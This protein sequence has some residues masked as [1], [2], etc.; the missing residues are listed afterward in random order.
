MRPTKDQ[1]EERE[2]LA[3]EGQKRCSVRSGCGEIKSVD[4]FGSHKGTWDNKN[5]LCRICNRNNSSKYYKE[6]R[7]ASK[8]YARQRYLDNPEAK[9]EYHVKRSQ[10]DPMHYRLQDGKKRAK[11]AGAEWEHISSTD[12]LSHWE[13]EGIDA[14]VCYYCK[15]TVNIDDLHLDHGIPLSRGGSHVV[16]NIF[17]AHGRCNQSKKDRTVAEYLEHLMQ[18]A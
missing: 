11:R 7:E 2:R 18:A 9:R 5:S 16:D 15:Q 8:A 13:Q 3:K 1:I 12:L 10:A 14:E 17:P 4:E 6:N